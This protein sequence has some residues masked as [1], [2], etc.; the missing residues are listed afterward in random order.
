MTTAA[1]TPEEIQ[2]YIAKVDSDI[3]FFHL[4]LAAAKDADKARWKEAID[5]ALDIRLVLMASRDK[6]KTL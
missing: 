3:A 2:K 1:L 6:Q 4:T 5:N